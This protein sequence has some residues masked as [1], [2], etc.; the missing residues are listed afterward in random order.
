MYT[1]LFLF[2]TSRHTPLE[3]PQLIPYEGARFKK[4]HETNSF[5]FE[6]WIEL[7]RRFP[8]SS[9]CRNQNV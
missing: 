2:F 8:E 7:S 1:S 4:I 9:E 3:M 6:Q 5:R